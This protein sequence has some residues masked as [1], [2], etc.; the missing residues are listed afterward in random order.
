MEDNEGEIRFVCDAFIDALTSGVQLLG[1]T[2][3][4]TLNEG[5][6]VYYCSIITI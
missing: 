1:E 2:P 4:I 5:L 6:Y 3:K